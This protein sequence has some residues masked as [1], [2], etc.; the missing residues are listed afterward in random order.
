MAA[1]ALVLLVGVA[2]A[3]GVAASEEPADGLKRAELIRALSGSALAPSRVG[4]LLANSE[5]GQDTELN[6]RN[7]QELV[8]M[9][10]IDYEACHLSTLKYRKRLCAA[11]EMAEAERELSPVARVNL[12]RF[13][14]DRLERQLSLCRRRFGHLLEA[15]SGPA[16]QRDWQ[17]VAA[18]LRKRLQQL[19]E[20]ALLR[21][22]PAR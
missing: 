21:N 8:A 14:N 3:A 2:G 16:R 7:V 10:W 20:L 6:D 18:H 1:L 13:C 4:E 22:H 12:F 15:V 17:E 9:N 5:P 11:F 19:D